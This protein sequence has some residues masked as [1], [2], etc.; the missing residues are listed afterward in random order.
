ME[1]VSL[2][3]TGF[4]NLVAETVELAAGTNL[5]LGA[6]GA[7]KTS[8]LEAV[9]VLGTL[10]SFRTPSLR[11][12]ARH[13]GDGFLLEGLVRCGATTVRIAQQVETAAGVTRQLSVNGHPAAV[14]DY[15]LELP[16]VTL[17][18]DDREL[19]VGPPQNR[20]TF[21]DRAGF[22]LD[23]RLLHELRR[24]RRALRQ[25]NAGLVADLPDRQLEPWEEALAAAA[26]R[27]VD[28]RRRLVARLAP[29]LSALVAEIGD[30]A[31]GEI[32]ADY[33]GGA[34]PLADTSGEMLVNV[35][36]QRYNESRARDRQA[37]HTADGPHRHDLGLRVD[38]RP[39][40]DVLSSGQTKVV[41]AALRIAA[42]AEIEAERREQLPIVID[43]VD[44]ELD[45]AILT[46]L[47]GR[48]GGER[49]MFLS[50][51]HEEL[52]VPLVEPATRLWIAAGACVRREDSQR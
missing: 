21:L 20:R 45:V 24:Y 51:A 26:A 34:D 10:R 28:H 37:G 42:L 27:V 18:S 4:R 11:R 5:V 22:L 23:P 33:R 32:T 14:G 9:A 39:V 46:N 36:R 52:V 19:V 2:R 6:N 48:L 31:I 41:A 1:L 7:G 49:Q 40:R 16:V 50:S 25:R 35:Y 8:L 29:R 30:G 12:V 43:D 15:L 3:A 44:A 13:G 17:T 47:V 38:G